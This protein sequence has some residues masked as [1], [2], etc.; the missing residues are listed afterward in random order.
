LWL[1]APPAIALAGVLLHRSRAA[2]AFVAIAVAGVSIAAGV[3]G[4]L[5]PLWWYGFEHLQALTVLRELYDAAALTALAVAALCA[6]A[7]ARVRWSAVQI[8]LAAIVALPMVYIA[9]RA[10][11]QLTWVSPQS[12]IAAAVDAIAARSGD[13]RVLPLP[14]DAPLAVG[15]ARGGFSPLSIGIG[16]HPSAAATVPSSPVTYLAR[17][18]EAGD[19]RTAAALANR[20]GV[21]IAVAVPSMH[22]GFAR[23]AE[24]R[25]KTLARSFPGEDANRARRTAF[26][27]PRVAVVPFSAAA[28]TLARPYIG[29]RDLRAVSGGQPFDVNTLQ[30]D[31]SPSLSWVRT[32]LW[33]ILPRWVFAESSG[34]FTARTRA[35]LIVPPAWIVA[36]DAVGTIHAQACARVR[37]LDAHFALLRCS[38]NPEL[39]GSAPLVVA[40]V[41]LGGSP[42]K[43]IAQT[44]AAGDARVLQTDAARLVLHVRGIAGSALVLRE[45]YDSGW[46]C[47]L[48]GARHVLVDGYA[49]AWILPSNVNDTVTIS[50]RP[51]A[52]FYV[53]LAVSIGLVALFAIVPITLRLRIARRLAM[54]P[55]T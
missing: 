22:S 12:P 4:P 53:A 16:A 14:V 11:A 21:G 42:A 52:A 55:I 30:T 49:N 43:S 39:R 1:W 24:P 31:A 3:R 48:A 41:T 33:P 20:T 7:L 6:L 8:V 26:S 27:A 45:R 17:T 23:V 19:A 36:G 47:S 38:Q 25:L 44:G 5:A 35:Q 2:F 40:S 32:A 29:A 51:A 50:Y 37:R 46:I 15:D 28:G 54:Q 13:D 34:V 9:S 18:I 10:S